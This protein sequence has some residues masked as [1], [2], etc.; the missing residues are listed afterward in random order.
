VLPDKW[1]VRVA[2]AAVAFVFVVFLNVQA[3]SSQ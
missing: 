3:H 2:A 1:Y